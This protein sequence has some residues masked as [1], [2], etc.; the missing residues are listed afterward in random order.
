MKRMA[1]VLVLVASVARGLGTDDGCKIAIVAPVDGGE[2]MLHVY[3]DGELGRLFPSPDAFSLKAFARDTLYSAVLGRL[4]VLDA[5]G[6]ATP[7]QL[8]SWT[9][10]PDFTRWTLRLRPG[11]VFHNGRRADAADLEYTLL[12]YLLS[13]RP[14]PGKALRQQIL[15]AERI[16]EGEPFRTGMVE[17][18]QV[19]DDRT[20]EVTLKRSDRF[21]PLAL[22]S[23]RDALVAREAL[24][25]DHF[26]WKEAPVGAGP[27]RVAAF[28]PGAAWVRLEAFER[29]VIPAEEGA[30]RALEVRSALDATKVDFALGTRNNPAPGRLEPVVTEFPVAIPGVYFNYRSPLGADERFRRAVARAVDREAL[31]RGLA[32]VRPTASIVP[33][34]LATL[35]TLP[36][37]DVA[38]AKR[39]VQAIGGPLKIRVPYAAP[40]E[41]ENVWIARLAAQLAEVGIELTVEAVAAKP[42]DPE[43][44]ETPFY[45]LG[46]IPDVAD[47]VALYSV[48]REGGPWIPKLTAPDPQFEGLLEQPA[49]AET[50]GRLR[51]RFAERAYAVPLLEQRLVYFV[52]RQ[53]VRDV[54]PQGQRHLVRFELLKL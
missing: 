5:K 13:P 49:D 7:G 54:S 26:S 24:A 36:P 39:L 28:D 16:R 9:P 38:E 37:R 20:V 50:E 1:L 35:G 30:P 44:R 14:S 12:R 19:L 34:N 10:S 53:V 3:L 22:S 48:F 15:G 51:A 43:D 45:F 8:E 4:L 29:A 42:F 25:A 31:A 17:G 23:S 18:L 11:I 40:L 27:Y 21:F 52:N 41:G 32:T 47:P 6:T 46:F 2:A 33:S